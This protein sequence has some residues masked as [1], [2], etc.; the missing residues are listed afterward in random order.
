MIQAGVYSSALNYTKAVA[1]AGTKD[2]AAVLKILRATD[3]EDGFARHGRLRADNLMVH[4]MYLAQVKSPDQSTKPADVYNILGIVD[5]PDTAQPLE[6][7]ACP[8]LRG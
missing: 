2:P 7:S 1:S 5:G 8:M 4:Q 6:T 3:I